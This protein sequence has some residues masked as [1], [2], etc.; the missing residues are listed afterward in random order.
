LSGEINIIKFY[1]IF[2]TLQ[3]NYILIKKIKFN[4]K[5]KNVLYY[6]LILLSD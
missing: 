2:G 6:T 5:I 1:I 4:Y 3:F